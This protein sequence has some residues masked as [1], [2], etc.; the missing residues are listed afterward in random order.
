MYRPLAHSEF[1][2]GGSV[3]AGR[4]GKASRGSED[5]RKEISKP[6]KE[7]NIPERETFEQRYEGG[8]RELK[9]VAPGDSACVAP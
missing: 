6:G 3:R 9:E 2:G 5:W 7:N 4:P 1:K 8:Q